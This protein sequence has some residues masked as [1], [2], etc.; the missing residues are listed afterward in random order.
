MC[1]LIQFLLHEFPYELFV[2]NKKLSVLHATDAVTYNCLMI[3]R[4]RSVCIQQAKNKSRFRIRI[5]Y[6]YKEITELYY[7]IYTDV[8][9][10]NAYEVNITLQLRSSLVPVPLTYQRIEIKLGRISYTRVHD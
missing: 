3:K 8:I 9:S 6:S 7:H 1:N 4:C 5:I 10:E 2:I